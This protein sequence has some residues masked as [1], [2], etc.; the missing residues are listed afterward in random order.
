[1]TNDG[2][3]FSWPRPVALGVLALCALTGCGDPNPGRGA[4]QVAPPSNVAAPGAADS[5]SEAPEGLTGGVVEFT[6][7]RGVTLVLPVTFCAGAGTVL[8]VVGREGE[9]QVDV[10][11]IE[12]EMMRGKAPIEESTETTYRFAG[13]ESGRR[14]EELWESTSNRTVIREGDTTRIEGEMRGRRM[15][16][17]GETTFSPPQPIDDDQTYRFSLLA[18]CAQ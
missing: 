10:R 2:R 14:Y 17:T 3:P 8:T 6:L 13:D 15:Y 9:T 11:I 7:D 12:N 1:M 16:A 4:S 5:S 18:R